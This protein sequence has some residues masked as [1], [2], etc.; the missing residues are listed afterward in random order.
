MRNASNEEEKKNILS[1]VR[2]NIA[3][4][5]SFCQGMHEVKDCEVLRKT[6]CKFCGNSGHKANVRFC[7]PLARKV[8]RDEEHRKR[9]EEIVCFG[10]NKK[11]HMKGDCPVLA[12]RNKKRDADFPVLLKSE[13][14]S[15]SAKVKKS[16]DWAK[17]V[18]SNRPSSM[19][20]AVEKANQE[21]VRLQTEKKEKASADYL[22]R[23][24]LRKQRHEEYR[25]KYI[26]EMHEKYGTR[27]FNFVKVYRDGEFD[28][29]IAEEH[30]WNFEREQEEQEYQQELADYKREQEE[31]ERERKRN[32]EKEEE[33]EYNRIN[34]SL[35]RF[36]IW[37]Q[38]QED[39]ESDAIDLDMEYWGSR[40][41]S[42]MGN[43]ERYAPEEYAR[44]CFRTGL[45]LDYNA[46]VLENQ[47][48]MKEWLK[49]KAERSN[50]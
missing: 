14:V 19:V 23:C 48:L 20:D 36:A 31:K 4:I 1:S 9:M 6:V 41:L 24:E 39:E 10:C 35:K 38:Q 40:Q 33:R 15:A 22:A 45:M 30:R 11:G 2:K 8:K 16:N 44:E 3:P 12:E 27:W 47:Q 5:C 18:K 28:N 43:Y 42:A 46:K 34:M 37:E 32:A 25:R 26:S 13:T 29:E 17:A 7:E 49:E 50:K 21:A